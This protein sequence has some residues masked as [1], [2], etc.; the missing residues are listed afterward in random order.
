MQDLAEDAVH[1]R[2]RLGLMLVVQAGE[3]VVQP[4]QFASASMEICAC[5]A[6][7]T[8]AAA[9]WFCRH[10]YAATSA[11]MMART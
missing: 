2:G 5:S 9:A 8:G 1:G 6:P 4:G 11:S 10:V 3:P 7:I